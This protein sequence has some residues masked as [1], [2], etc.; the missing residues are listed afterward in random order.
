MRGNVKGAPGVGA[1]RYG[2][3]RNELYRRAFTHAPI[4]IALV[5]EDGVWLE[6]NPACCAMLGCASTSLIGQPVAARAL[7][8]DRAVLARLLATGEEL[9]DP[10]EEVRF[11]RGDGAVIWTCLRSSALESE[12]GARAYIVQF[13]DISQQKEAEQRLES[14]LAHYRLLAENMSDMVGLHT[15]DGTP[16]YASPSS[17]RMLGYSPEHL[18]ASP[19]YTLTHPDD[20]PRVRAAQA[21]LLADKQPVTVLCRLRRSDGDYLWCEM[22]AT[23]IL[24]AAGEVAH[25]QT[26]TRDVSERLAAQRALEA[27]ERKY[28]AIFDAQPSAILDTDP[29]GVIREANPAVDALFGY[30][31]RELIGRPLWHLLS[32][33]T[34]Y[35]AVLAAL[36]E[37]APGVLW[38]Y[39]VEGQRKDGSRFPAELTLAPQEGGGHVWMLRDTTARERA[40]RHLAEVQ[41][42]LARGREE[43]RVHIARE[44][45]DG[46]VQDV[47]GVSYRLANLL[48]QTELPDGVA[49]LLEGLRGDLVDVVKQLRGTISELRPAAFEEFGL[50]TSL[51]GYLAKLAR[52]HAERLPETRLRV[53]GDVDRLAESVK[54][55]LFRTVQEAM[56]N[57]IRHAEARAVEIRVQRLP[58]E[59]LLAVTDDG[60][61]F[62]VPENLVDLTEREHFG[63]AGIAER[64]KLMG[65]TV[66]LRSQR[67]RGSELAVVLPVPEEDHG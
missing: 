32:P 27:R 9:A 59:V 7:P 13:Q 29:A 53:S 19:A 47:I 3:S 58:G 50:E 66:A 39:P 60:K 5:A 45:H 67:G 41:Q 21:R 49:A 46:A 63:L 57:V 52:H 24:D 62:A 1:R 40:R 11:Q 48:A 6:V 55:C 37:Q 23:P 34:P 25:I 64:V 65:G 36:K 33:R 61:G 10:E 54:I 8:E 42:R 43:E 16:L 44:L 18:M 14:S 38:E 2:S 56:S 31:E 28:R 12:D 22:T 30:G 26:T 4:G 51:E 17:Y 20:A 35:D 15:P